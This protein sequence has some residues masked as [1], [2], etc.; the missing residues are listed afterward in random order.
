ME[1]KDLLFSLLVIYVSA[2]LM[3]ELAVRLGQS[4]VLGELLAGVVIG[5]SVLGLVYE[6]EILRLLGQ[7]GVILLLF[8][9]GLESDLSSFLKVGRSAALVA[10]IGVIVPFVLGY[11]VALLFHLTQLQAVFI[12]ATLTATSVAISARSLADLGKLNTSEGN[13]IL[14]AAVLD[15]ILGLIT[16]SVI[17][18]L[19]TAGTISWPEAGR[20]FGLALLF[21]IVSIAAGIRY[22][23]L[24][25]RLVNQT[26][27]RGTLVIAALSFAL[28][29]AYAAELVRIAPF[30]G[31]FAA[32]LI[33]ARTEHQ[34][35]IQAAIKP[36]AD[37]FIPIFFVLMGA[38]VTL[39][40][41]N[42]LE[43]QNW[44]VL[45]LAGGLIV[46]ALIGK[47]AAG[48]G[49]IGPR[50]NRWVVGVGMIP[51][52]EVGVIFATMGLAH[53]VL[54]EAQYGAILLVV[55]VT[56]FL[57]PILLKRVFKGF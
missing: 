38:A 9:I 18:G 48:F 20:T 30:I 25:S 4:P 23:H 32:G 29:F 10:V 3:G 46:V 7:I 5:G 36:V 33:L 1:L 27:T 8:E 41:L 19:A 31:A 16:L 54:D 24:F 12:G 56:T 26:R 34:A 52:G 47:L 45:L 37:V 22:A 35:H 42:P 39:H 17:I 40:H 44:P 28:L 53:H 6:T 11:A 43:R 2:R 21:L 49:A 13:M 57:S 50:I 51:R 55:V 14:G 15:D